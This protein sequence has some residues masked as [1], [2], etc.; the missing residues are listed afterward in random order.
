MIKR[1]AKTASK[2]QVFAAFD[3]LAA[4]FKKLESAQRSA[5][6]S[7][8]GSVSS[9]V[10]VS[11]QSLES[12]IDGLSTLRGDFGTAV[13]AL[14][15]QLTTEAE[16]LLGLRTQADEMVR[17]LNEFYGL[18]V[19][20][21]TLQAV[22]EEYQTKS[23]SFQREMKEKRETFE[24]TLN[25]RSAAWKQEQD[26]RARAIKERDETLKKSR[27]RDQEEYSY[28]L[29][30]RRKADEDSYQQ[31]R[32]KQQRE[33]DAD[34]A[35]KE[36]TRADREKQVA[37]QEKQYNDYKA[38]FDALPGK[39]DAAIKKARTE[40]Q[41]IANSQAKVKSDMT[42]KEAEGERRVFEL[43]IKNLEASIKERSTRI[44]S[45]SQQLAQ[46]LKQGQ[47]LAVK[48]I[49]G[50]S[51]ASTFGAVKEIALEQAKNAPKNK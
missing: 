28:N 41:G 42:A 22:I 45:L 47:D 16:S 50:A 51:N 5:P 29:A 46:A 8:G 6:P 25:E 17:Q 15:D 2:D 36:K 21:D 18:E 19:A 10:S 13:S 23:V 9:S 40:G 39:L 34:L 48:A 33:L 43:Q 12:T 7:D 4:E 14:S 1:P 31:E 32:L 37:E 20:D 27:Q 11:G 30:Q 3:Q 24:R 49:E 35:T 44:E 26:E 38:E